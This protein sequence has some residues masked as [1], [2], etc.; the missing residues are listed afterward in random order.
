MKDAK[1]PEI[2]EKLTKAIQNAQKCYGYADV[3]R[4][5]RK[6]REQ[7]YLREKTNVAKASG[8]VPFL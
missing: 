1:L 5:G 8:G 7:L 3:V 4:R 6:S 2:R